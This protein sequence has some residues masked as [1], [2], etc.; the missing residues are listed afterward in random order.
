MQQPVPPARLALHQILSRASISPLAVTDPAPAGAE[1]DLV[2]DAALRAPDHGRIRPWSFVL[3]RG[4]ARRR[5]GEVLVSALLARDPGASDMMLERERDRPLLAPLT[6]ALGTRLNPAHKVPE[7]EQVLSVGAA[8]MNMLNALHLLGYGAMWVTGANAYDPNVAA[9][10]GFQAPDRLVGFIMTGTP[11]DPPASPARPD[12]GDHV[13]D[14]TGPS[15][16]A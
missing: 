16:D 13:R 6:I 11:K 15:T 3:I 4:E 12:R 8:A 7:G 10:L 5:Y 9:A 1:L 2:L 14:W